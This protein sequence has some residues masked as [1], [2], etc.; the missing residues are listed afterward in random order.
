MIH[1]YCRCSTNESRQDIDRQIRALKDAG[2]DTIYFEYEH[3]DAAHK[4]ELEKMIAATAPGDT[5][6]TMEV[7]RISRSTKQ[8]CEIIDTVRERHLKLIIL[9]SITVDC[10][11]GEL[12]P[13][14][15]A[16]LQIAGVF[17]E[18]EL[19]MTRARVRSGMENARA[20]GAAIGRPRTT[21]E[22]IPPVFL[23]LYPLYKSGQ[24]TATEFARASNIGRTTLYKYL[25]IVES[26]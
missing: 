23:K 26:A 18:L 6:V 16:F 11:T 15:R 4:Q 10:T 22:Q 25:K 13:M 20:K 1:G 12:D 3:G 21:H 5:I 7:S 19:S 9:G 14:T 24:M 17:A 2:A 8:L